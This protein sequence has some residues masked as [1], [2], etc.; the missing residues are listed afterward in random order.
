MQQTKVKIV[1]EP[2]VGHTRYAPVAVIG[3]WL[4]QADFL[5]LV[6]AELSWPIKTYEHTL[7]DKLETLLASILV[8]NR[9]VYQINTTIRP[10]L[11]LAQAWGQAQ[12]AEQSTIADMLRS[13]SKIT[14]YFNMAS[15]Q[16]FSVAG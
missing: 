1:L 2:L 7:V 3:Y 15:A 16:A 13:C 8:G 4:R 10:D 5:A 11:S 12:F 9:A 14:S 6:W